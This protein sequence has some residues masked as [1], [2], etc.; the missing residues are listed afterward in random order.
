MSFTIGER[1]H[2]RWLVSVA[3][4][5]GLTACGGGGDQLATVD[6][7]PLTL[8]AKPPP[9][10]PSTAFC[11]SGA[12]FN[13]SLG[14][15]ADATNAYGPFT[16]A[17]TDRCVAN[18]T[19]AVCTATAAYLVNGVSLARQ[20]WSLSLAHSLRG[21]ASCP[22]GSAANTSFDNLCVETSVGV[23]YAYA[24]FQS[25]DTVRCGELSGGNEC[26]STRWLAPFYKK[27]AFKRKLQ[28]NLSA[29]WSGTG[30]PSVSVTV[31]TPDQGSVFA[32]VGVAAPTTN[33]VNAAVG[34]Y[35]FASVSKNFTA[36][37]V[38][39]LQELGYLSIEDR[40]AQHLVVPG[41]ANGDTMTIRQLLN[42]TAGVGNYLDSSQSFLS[43]TSA[44]RTYTNEDIV[45]YI[46]QVGPSGAPGASYTYSNGNFFVLGMLVEKKLGVS[47]QA[48]MSQLITQPLGLTQTFSDITSSPTQ[49]ISNL[50]ESSRAYAYSTTSVKGAGGVV[51]TSDEVAKYMRAIFGGS[52]LSATSVAAMKTPSTQ[53]TTYG[54]GTILFKD[55]AGVP[56]FGHTGTLL[57]YKSR[58]YYVPSWD[59]AVALTMNDYPSSR[60]QSDIESAIY[61]TTKT[62]YQP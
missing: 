33:P 53:S 8:A 59:A 26:Y 18:G 31:A 41:L 20:R 1:A 24:G 58:A 19:G 12:T 14:F 54:L 44:W 13:T 3:F 52:L 29:A 4:L 37:M 49:R 57:N 38:M 7:K 47:I 34:Q 23:S 45:A 60:A 36:T 55:S 61:T 56:Y 35:R 28:S 21:T 48:A 62:Q 46:N 16:K 40:L 15:C 25:L 6:A 27:V 39:R 5:I 11:P 30:I 32:T 22:L 43:S 42:H 51:S 10:P 50:V 9:A 2:L 17:M